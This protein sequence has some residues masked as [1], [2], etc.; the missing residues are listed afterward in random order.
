MPVDLGS[1]EEQC[2]TPALPRNKKREYM[3]HFYVF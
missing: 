2:E 3:L 1:L